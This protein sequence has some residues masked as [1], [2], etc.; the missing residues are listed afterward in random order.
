MDLKDFISETIQQISL[1]VKDAME[2]CQDIDVIVNPDVTIGS[3]G[4][5]YVP[6]DNGHTAMQR[7]VQV[8][9]MDISVVVT[10]STENN[11]GGKIGISMLGVSGTSK[12]VDNTSNTNRVKFSIPVCLPV[13]K[14]SLENKYSGLSY[15]ISKSL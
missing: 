14:V 3:D 12:E 11:I 5:Y 15:P 10:A 13:S 4:D 8:I 9:D 2:K 1:G 7:R 6:E